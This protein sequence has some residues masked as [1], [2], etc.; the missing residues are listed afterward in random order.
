MQGIF[1]RCMSAI[2]RE[3]RLCGRTDL[4]LPDLTNGAQLLRNVAN[5]DRVVVTLAVGLRVRVAWVLPRL[6]IARAQARERPMEESEN[7]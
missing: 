3:V 1:P 4:D 5:V 6:R 2:V 7:M